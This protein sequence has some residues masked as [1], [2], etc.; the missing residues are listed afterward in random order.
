MLAFLDDILVIE[1][2]FE[3][4]LANLREALARFRQ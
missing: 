4:H 1:K 3:N 2:H